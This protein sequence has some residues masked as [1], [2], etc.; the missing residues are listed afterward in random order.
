MVEPK[1]GSIWKIKKQHVVIKAILD[2]VVCFVR[3]SVSEDKKLVATSDPKVIKGTI[4]HKM[5]LSLAENHMR[6]F[7]SSI[8]KAEQKL[9]KGEE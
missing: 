5:R 1:I 6:Y 7:A 3:L 2:G 4:V 9:K 8:S